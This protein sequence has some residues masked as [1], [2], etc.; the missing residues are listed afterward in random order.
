[1]I[2]KTNL[3][4]PSCVLS[5]GDDVIAEYQ[6]LLEENMKYYALINTPELNDFSKAVVIE[7]V[8]QRERFGREHDV[9]KTV[10][11]WFWVLCYLATKATQ[12]YRYGDH[13]K[14]LHHLVTSAALLNNWHAYAIEENNKKKS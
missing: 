7:A 1:M 4:M 12:A 5:A 13:E 6:K 3:S 11:E 9:C 10:D 8:H 14:Y 2:K